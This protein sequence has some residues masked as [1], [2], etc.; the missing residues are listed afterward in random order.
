ML[1]DR[2]VFGLTYSSLWGWAGQPLPATATFDH[3]DPVC[4]GLTQQP[5]G[6][7]GHRSLYEIDRIRPPEGSGQGEL[8]AGAGDTVSCKVNTIIRPPKWGGA[9]KNVKMKQANAIIKYKV[10]LLL[11]IL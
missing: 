11:K 10:D 8:S 5:D 3:Y 4:N 7:Y 6:L 2:A 9:F 1:T